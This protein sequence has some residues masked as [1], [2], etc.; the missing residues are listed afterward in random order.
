MN[1]E[2][3]VENNI[4]YLL[5]G[6]GRAKTRNEAY[7]KIVN[8]KEL[9]I[10]DHITAIEYYVPDLFGKY[11]KDSYRGAVLG[12]P[13]FTANKY[14]LAYLAERLALLGYYVVVTDIRG[15]WGMSDMEAN[16]GGIA[17]D[18]RTS[19]QY[20]KKARGVSNVAVFGHS[21]GAISSCYASFGYS[22]EIEN[23]INEFWKEFEKFIKTSPE[24]IKAVRKIMIKDYSEL[25]TNEHKKMYA[26]EQ[27]LVKFFSKALE[28]NAAYKQ[29]KVL[30]KKAY[31]NAKEFNQDVK[32]LVLLA[33]VIEMKKFLPAGEIKLVT[34]LIHYATL[35][36]VPVGTIT[37][38]FA[39][40]IHKLIL[41]MGGKKELK[42]FN[43]KKGWEG[44][45]T[46][47]QGFATD[48]PAGFL[49]YFVNHN[50]P[51][52]FLG[53]IKFFAS[54][55]DGKGSFAKWFFNNYVKR[56]PKLFAYGRY[57]M[58]VVPLDIHTM[59]GKR[60][61]KLE[62]Y[63]GDLGATKTIT[64]NF[65]HV[66]KPTKSFFDLKQHFAPLIFDRNEKFDAED[67]KVLNEE[68]QDKISNLKTISSSIDA[69]KKEV[70]EMPDVQKVVNRK[71]AAFARLEEIRNLK[72]K[73]PEDYKEQ[74]KLNKELKSLKKN[75]AR[76]VRWHSRD[77]AKLVKQREKLIK[78]VNKYK[79][80]VL[81]GDFRLTNEIC[82]FLSNHLDQNVNAV[83]NYK[84]YSRRAGFNR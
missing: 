81:G 36:Q 18:I 58:G 84:A 75:Y 80:K 53:V 43:Y 63:Y 27:E 56:M 60:R 25:S 69:I 29:L 30:L 45:K 33:P 6:F 74:D 66:L 23:K 3:E 61:H 68:K 64:G 17:E 22:E 46:A 76:L 82:K 26:A 77:Y 12:V 2:K 8:T 41:G 38:P 5:G 7:N 13:G 44:N 9:R 14:A 31:Y 72:W 49:D 78:E 39:G 79:K 4:N 55:P 48:D 52:D 50:E 70:A 20:I 35:K 71:A 32:C 11:Q 24:K 37:K 21:L 54:L 19:V 10:G 67:I 51:R 28:M 16:I 57:D 65:T 59:Y 62:T 34:N 40:V 15:H 47:I 73:N 1:W 83:A 42:K